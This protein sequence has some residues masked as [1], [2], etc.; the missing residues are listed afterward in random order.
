MNAE[1]HSRTTTSDMEPAFKK[2]FEKALP[3]DGHSHTLTLGEAHDTTE[4]LQWL[5]QHLSQLKT[6]Y[7][8]TTIGV[9]RST[10]MNPLFWAYKDGTLAE[11]LGS[12]EK[13]QQYMQTVLMIIATDDCEENSYEQVKLLISAMDAGMDVVAYDSRNSYNDW[14]NK[15][16]EGKGWVNNKHKKPEKYWQEN[17]ENVSIRNKCIPE[18]FPQFMM[19]VEWLRQLKPEYEKKFDAAE[20]LIACGHQKINAG[21]LTSDA[22]SATLFNAM[23]RPT[24]NRITIGG[25]YHIN[26]VGS[27]NKLNGLGSLNKPNEIEKIHGTFPH[28]LFAMGQPP[29]AQRPHQVTAAVIATTAVGKRINDYTKKSFFT[30]PIIQSVFGHHVSHL[31]LDHGNIEPLWQPPANHPCAVS[32]ESKFSK[33]PIHNKNTDDVSLSNARTEAHINPL[34]MPDIRAAS[35]ALRAAMHGPSN[36]RAR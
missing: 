7:G 15:V 30:D 8:I 24:G 12:K 2:F 17:R 23:A 10:F 5:Q 34:L 21:A 20:Q 32:L 35:D 14:Q 16:H 27:L 18:S 26:G 1:P 19:E 29:E 31:N 13:A 11:Q 22:L 9:E 33:K 3:N 6:D 25:V 4:H 28:H 36:E